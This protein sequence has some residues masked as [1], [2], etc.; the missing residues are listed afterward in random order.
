MDKKESLWDK[1][2]QDQAI[3][4]RLAES[5]KTLWR[6][7]DKLPQDELVKIYVAICKSG[8]EYDPNLHYRKK[9]LSL[10]SPVH[11][12]ELVNIR[13]P[14]SLAWEVE[15]SLFVIERD[16]PGPDFP[17]NVNVQEITDE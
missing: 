14:I 12:V 7:L 15:K 2:A 13:M 9:L 5:A 1:V 3:M 6:K 17:G 11:L 16:I 8:E 4:R 10:I